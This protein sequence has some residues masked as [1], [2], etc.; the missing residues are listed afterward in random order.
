MTDI[1][2]NIAAILPGRMINRPVDHRGVS[3]DCAQRRACH[4]H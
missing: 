2:P 3:Y 4:E 1:R